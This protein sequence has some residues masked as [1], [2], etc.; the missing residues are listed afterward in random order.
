ML[1]S[2][3]VRGLE[4]LS[5]IV[6]KTPESQLCESLGQGMFDMKTQCI[7]ACNMALRGYLPLVGEPVDLVSVDLPDK[8]NLLHVIKQVSGQIHALPQIDVLD[9]SIEVV[10]QAGDRTLQLNQQEFVYQF[11]LPNFYFH[12]SMAYAIA[13]NTGVELSKGDFDGLHEYQPG[14]SFV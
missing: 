12:I 3:L 8:P 6:T 11:V 13:R 4:Q 10:E 1:Q 14:F 9:A 7:V 5:L 2:T